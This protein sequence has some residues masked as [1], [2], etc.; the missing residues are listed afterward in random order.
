MAC[1]TLRNLGD[2]VKERF[3][4]QA[5]EHHRPMEEEVRIIL[6]DAVKGRLGAHRGARATGLV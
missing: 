2:E 5:A 6:R 4:A 1:I 3:Q